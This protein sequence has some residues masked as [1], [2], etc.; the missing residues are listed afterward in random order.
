MALQHPPWIV[1]EYERATGVPGLEPHL[2]ESLESRIQGASK[3]TLKLDELLTDGAGVVIEDG[4]E[5]ELICLDGCTP[6]ADLEHLELAGRSVTVPPPE[7]SKRKYT[8]QGRRQG[9]LVTGST[10]SPV[11]LKKL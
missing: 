6:L 2:R 11:V 10:K 1:A 3:R 7:S 5:V 4:D 8:K 9:L